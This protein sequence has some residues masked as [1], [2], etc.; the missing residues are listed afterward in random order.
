[1][2]QPLGNVPGGAGPRASWAWPSGCP[3]RCWF[4]A[5]KYNL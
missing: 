2:R 1:M 3:V 4:H 5:Q